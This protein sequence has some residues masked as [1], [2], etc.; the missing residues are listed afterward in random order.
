VRVLLTRLSA[1]GDIVHTWPLAAA[2]AKQETAVELAWMVEEPFLPLVASHPAVALA[3][4]VATRRWRHRP[5]AAA[6]RR[7]ILELRSMVQSFAP[8]LVLDPQG[9]IKSAYWGA[10]ARAPQRV[11][12]SPSHRRERLAG[13]FYTRTVTPPPEARHVVDIN[14]SL[15]T[16]VGLRAPLGAHPDG[17]F[18]LRSVPGATPLMARGAVGLLP[19]TGGRG[20]AWQLENYTALARKLT[21]SGVP[22]TV[23]WGPGERA[24][25]ERV[26]AD[27]GARTE[28]APRTSI[29]ELADLMSRFALIVGGD[30]GPVHLAASLGVPTVAIFVA[31]DPNRNGP[32]GK[33]VRVVSAAGGRTRRG[34]ARKALAGEVAIDA[35]FQAVGEELGLSGP[36]S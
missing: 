26:V 4:P 30:T 35:V 33:R 1:L 28:L 15:L 2:L 22:V 21:D 7:E 31:T 29:P 19:A 23:I 34:G 24:L 6:T 16:A 12:F 10:V 9:L 3:I 5:L 8:D 27:A 18:L 14:L 25:A 13:V 11:G 17:R 20:K 32:R 36:A